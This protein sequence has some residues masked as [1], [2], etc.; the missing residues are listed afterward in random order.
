MVG[1]LGALVALCLATD[2]LLLVSMEKYAR[3]RREISA[4]HCSTEPRRMPL[5]KICDAFVAEAEQTA[6]M[7]HDVR[8]QAHAAMALAERGDY[9]RAREHIYHRWIIL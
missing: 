2:W 9:A 3:K 5:A 4:P 8:N 6:K 1:I 7:R